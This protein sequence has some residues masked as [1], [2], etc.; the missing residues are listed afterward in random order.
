M[1][2]HSKGKDHMLWKGTWEA[3]KVLGENVTLGADPG[4]THSDYASES[5]LDDTVASLALA[6]DAIVALDGVVDTTIA[7]QAEIASDLDIDIASLAITAASCATLSDNSMVDTYHRHSELSA[8]DGTPDQALIVNDIG[9]IGIGSSNPAGARLKIVQTATTGNALWVYRNLNSEN[10]NLDLLFVEQDNSGDDRSCLRLQQDGSGKSIYIDHNGDGSSIEINN[11]G[12][13]IGIVVDG[14]GAGYSAIFNNG[15]VGIGTTAPATT[16]HSSGAVTIS[17]SA[18][19]S[20]PTNAGA[21]FVSGGA[22]WCIGG[23]GTQTL[24]G[25][26]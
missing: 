7:S 14:A 3:T 21:I 6:S 16:L 12:T 22:I 26:A 19:P 23:G 4:H 11:A 2:Y 24:L 13:G 15:N 18:A 8:S 1:V 25:A 17:N 9:E 10:T 5:I 20:T